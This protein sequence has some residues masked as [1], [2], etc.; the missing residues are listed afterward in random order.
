MI[1]GFLSQPDSLITEKIKYEL[2][3]D[4]HI[5]KQTV[6]CT[7]AQMNRSSLS[8]TLFKMFVQKKNNKTQTYCI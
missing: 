2:R 8:E 3:F 6:C 5:M 7:R 1:L 4:L